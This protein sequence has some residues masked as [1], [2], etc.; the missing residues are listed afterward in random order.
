MAHQQQSNRLVNMRSKQQYTVSKFLLWLTVGLVCSM[1]YVGAQEPHEVSW[2]AEVSAPAFPS[3]FGPCVCID[4]GHN[5]YH[6]AEG[7]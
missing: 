1:E 7:R 4:Q 6:T 3:G 5:N 2:R